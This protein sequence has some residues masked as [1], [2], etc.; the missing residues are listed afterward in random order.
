MEELERNR[1]TLLETYAD[2]IPQRLQRLDPEERRRIY[3][4]LRLRIVVDLDGD[5]EIVGVIGAGE[6]LCDP[7]LTS[8]Y[9]PTWRQLPNKAKSHAVPSTLAARA[10][11]TTMRP[12]R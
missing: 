4:M 11:V 8:G 2:L 6:M 3:A 5:M 1:D 12:A 9:T 7:G 10:S